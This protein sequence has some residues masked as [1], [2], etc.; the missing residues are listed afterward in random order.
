[1]ALFHSLYG[2]VIFHCM[3]ALHHLFIPLRM[4]CFYLLITV[5]EYSLLQQIFVVIVVQL[6]PTFC[7]PMDYSMPGFPVHHH[8]LELAQ[9]H[10]HWVGD[11]IQ[12]SHPLSSPSPPAFSLSQSSP[13][14]WDP[15]DC[16][17][18]GLLCPCDSLGKNPAVGYHFLLQGIFRT[19][20]SNLGLQYCGQIVYQ[21]LSHSKSHIDTHIN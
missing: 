14:L 8:P 18:P 12:P 9:T 15:M 2:W 10:A 5:N 7:D 20:G 4:D 6:C 1:M 13:T 17:P 11:A 3:Y 19:Q 21:S 16:S